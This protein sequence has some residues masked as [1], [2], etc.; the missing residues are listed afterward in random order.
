MVVLLVRYKAGDLFKF[1]LLA[2]LGAGSALRITFYSFWSVAI[3]ETFNPQS[4][5]GRTEDFAVSN[6]F[7]VFFFLT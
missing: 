5:N 2:V 6:G 7:V 1:A 4:A 3:G